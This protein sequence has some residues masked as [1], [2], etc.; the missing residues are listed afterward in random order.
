MSYP[1]LSNLPISMAKGLKKYPVFNTVV[2]K[3]AAGKG[4]ASFGLKPFPTWNFSFDLDSISGNE[5]Y[6]TSA[7]SA[8]LGVFIACGGQNKV[9]LFNDTQDNFVNKYT[10]AMV[11][12]TP[13]STTPMALVGNGVS[14]QFQ[15]ARNIG[16]IVGAT[17][18]IQ[19]VNGNINVYINGTITTAC[20]L[21]QSGI[22]TF[23]TAPTFGQVV[24]WA[25]SFYFPCRFDSDTIDATRTF[26]RNSGND[27]WD[28]N[29]IQFDSEFIQDSSTVISGGVSSVLVVPPTPFN[30]TNIIWVNG[31]VV[32][33][34]GILVGGVY[35]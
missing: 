25:G 2:Q 13:N 18:L 15:L 22:V 14:T 9:F 1:V 29:S 4:N 28:M 10:S 23:T 24:T 6:I 33:A 5:S 34:G 3:V 17:D 27:L 32:S 7:V 12:I 11:D 20:T 31:Q 16:G 8:M 21:S 30:T 26:T 19:T 35:V